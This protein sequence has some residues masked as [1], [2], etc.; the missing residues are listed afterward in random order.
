MNFKISNFLVYIKFSCMYKIENFLKKK[1]NIS[2]KIIKETCI[3]LLT[4]KFL[5]L[6]FNIH[7]NVTQSKHF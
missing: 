6:Y 5:L 2:T 4:P 7:N 3:N 1:Y